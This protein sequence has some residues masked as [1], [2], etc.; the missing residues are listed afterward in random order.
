MGIFPLSHQLSYHKLSIFLLFYHIFTVFKA[1]LWNFC[2]NLQ[3]DIINCPT[4]GTSQDIPDVPSP[5]PLETNGICSKRRNRTFFNKS[6]QNSHYSI[7]NKGRFPWH[8]EIIFTLIFWCV[9][10][11]LK[12]GVSVHPSVHPKFGFFLS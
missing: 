8:H 4:S 10:F 11:Y 6:K 2:I 12:E 5:T 9:H 7:Q 1:I 3:S